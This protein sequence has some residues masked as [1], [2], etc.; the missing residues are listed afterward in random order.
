MTSQRPATASTQQHPVTT[1]DFSGDQARY[2]AAYRRGYPAAVVDVLADTFGLDSDSVVLDLGC[3]TGQLTLPLAGVAGAVIGADPQPDMLRLARQTGLDHGIANI[4]WLLA[5]DTDL[6][7]LA[8]AVGPA[9][10]TAVTIGNAIHWMQPEQLFTNLRPL[11]Q[12][13]GGIAVIAN[14]SP[15]WLHD[16]PWAR[17]LRD[18]NEKWF[19]PI[20]SSCGTSAQERQPYRDALTAA[21]FPDIS[22]VTVSYDDTLSL[23][24]VLGHLRS[25]RPD[26]QLSPSDQHEYEAQL[27]DLLV[28]EEPSGVFVEH[29]DVVLLLAKR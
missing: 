8:R 18:H 12:P 5:A 24:Y 7:A 3:G 6:A 11:I 4:S 9:S 27:R 15:I 28:E 26:T 25:A 21:G 23:D 10:V 22:Q 1:T 29:V 17:A 13:G 14:G 16:T 2:Y 20:L 19:G